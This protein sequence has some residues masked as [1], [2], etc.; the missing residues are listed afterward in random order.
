MKGRE[1]DFKVGSLEWPSSKPQLENSVFVIWFYHSIN[2]AVLLWIKLRLIIFL[3]ID[4]L[5]KSSMFYI[6]RR[7]DVFILNIYQYMY[8][9]CLSLSLIW[10]TFFQP[11][12]FWCFNMLWPFPH[13]QLPLSLPHGNFWQVPKNEKLGIHAKFKI[14]MKTVVLWNLPKYHNKRLIL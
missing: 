9:F 7:R 2:V 6:Y 12:H 11:S 10:P 1:W 5:I 13:S 8:L 14:R 3:Y 4:K